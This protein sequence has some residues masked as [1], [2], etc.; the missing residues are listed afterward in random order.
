[1]LFEIYLTD[2]L[3]FITCHAI[4]QEAQ[5]N[6]TFLVVIII[7]IYIDEVGLYKAC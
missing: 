6:V 1:M 3:I 4:Q 7:K 5:M 2:H